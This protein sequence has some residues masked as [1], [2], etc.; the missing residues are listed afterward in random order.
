MVAGTIQATRRSIALTH[1][2]SVYSVH[3]FCPQDPRTSFDLLY[4][5]QMAALYPLSRCFVSV[6]GKGFH[7]TPELVA[8]TKT[9]FVA[10]DLE[11]DSVWC[12]ADWRGFWME[13]YHRDP[14]EKEARELQ[15]CGLYGASEPRLLQWFF[16]LTANG[17]GDSLW[18][19]LRAFGYQ[20]DL[21]LSELRD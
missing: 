1:P 21:R 10:C 9:I 2:G 20:G 8:A 19:V 14:S 15:E 7:P 6:D 4:R 11:D 13:V 5:A 18:A 17:K 12:A 3:F 16:E